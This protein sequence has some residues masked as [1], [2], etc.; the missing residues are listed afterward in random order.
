[1]FNYRAAG[2]SGSHT[3]P[4]EPMFNYRVAG[5]SGSHT[6]PTELTFNYRA[7][8]QGGSVLADR[9]LNIPRYFLPCHTPAVT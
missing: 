2:D 7:F 5:D 3:E 4:T 6:E 1:M 8:G 9:F